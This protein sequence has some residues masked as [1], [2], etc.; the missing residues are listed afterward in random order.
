MGTI[1]NIDG[2]GEN[3]PTPPQPEM[4]DC[5]DCGKDWG[6]GYCGTCKGMKKIPK[7]PEVDLNVVVGTL[8]DKINELKQIT[9]ELADLYCCP[10]FT[11][12]NF[13]KFVG[14]SGY[15]SNIPSDLLREMMALGQPI[16][17]Q[18]RKDRAAKIL[19]ECKS[20]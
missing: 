1:I 11:P 7:P 4:I 3:D 2:V 10:A 19:Q 13:A 15:D 8:E 20:L 9:V 16:A 17:I 18:N 5:P 14:L 12:T 6:H